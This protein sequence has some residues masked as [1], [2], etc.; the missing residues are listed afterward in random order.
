M[1]L[2]KE[3]IITRLHTH[4]SLNKHESRQLVERVLEIKKDT[5]P[6]K[7]PLSLGGLGNFR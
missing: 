7:N 2:T 4:L 6:R 3:K 1:P 5:Y